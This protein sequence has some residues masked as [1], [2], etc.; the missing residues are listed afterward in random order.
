MICLVCG[1]VTYSDSVFISSLRLL[2]ILKASSI[3]CI[4]LATAFWGKFLASMSP[5][6]RKMWLTL[7][8]PALHVFRFWLIATEGA[9][10]N[11]DP[12]V[13]APF[14]FSSAESPRTFAFPITSR[15]GSKP[16]RC[17]TGRASLPRQGN[18]FV[19]LPLVVGFTT[20]A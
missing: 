10:L 6:C 3:V 7:S 20:E 15:V 17:S 16:L 14:E 5:V 11:T 12:V 19:L 2:N 1:F 8:E 18:C 4:T 9:P 13:V